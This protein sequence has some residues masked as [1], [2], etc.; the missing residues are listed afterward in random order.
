[1]TAWEGSQLTGVAPLMQIDIRK[2][3][4]KIKKLCSIA[5]RDTDVSGFIFPCGDL[6][7]LHQLSESII[8]LQDQWDILELSDVPRD[9]LD[10]VIFENI[11]S[12]KDF[13]FICEPTAHFHIQINADWGNYYKD[14]STHFRRNIKRRKRMLQEDCKNYSILHL[15][16]TEIQPEHMD[17]IFQIQVNSRYTCTYET[18]LEKLFH[19]ELVKVTGEKGW[20]GI[21]I[22]TIDGVPAAYE[23]GFIHNKRFEFWHSGMDARFDQYTPGNILLLEMVERFCS[24]GIQELDMLRGGEEYKCRWNG[25]EQSYHHLKVIKK[26]S[27]KC[28]A[29]YVWLP[30][31]KTQLQKISIQNNHVNNN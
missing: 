5:N 15:R 23:Y 27:P 20:V 2:K 24:Q 4:A 29:L 16:G 8:Q 7:T 21:S 22:I 26:R 9:C 12:S 19:K 17:V 11:F 1:M 6:E 13:H 25:K 14:I 31:I 28:M 18:D 30:K 10:P 3:G